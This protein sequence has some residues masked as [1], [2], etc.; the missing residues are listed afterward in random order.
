MLF[1]LVGGAAK[2]FLLPYQGLC[3]W[4]FGHG[5]SP[6]TCRTQAAKDADFACG[7]PVIASENM[8]NTSEP[9]AS[10]RKSD[11]GLGPA[12][13]FDR[14]RFQTGGRHG[15][16]FPW[17]RTREDHRF[18][19]GIT[20]RFPVGMRPASARSRLER[21]QREPSP[22][23]SC[24]TFAVFGLHSFFFSPAKPNTINVP[25]VYSQG[26]KI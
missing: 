26:S 3:S 10:L 8:G 7:H 22:H 15:F 13:C 18:T 4:N 25:F 11:A 2:R 1:V 23:S 20:D 12:F 24:Q 9:L 5:T 6:N 19:L 16:A 14:T 21:K 17:R